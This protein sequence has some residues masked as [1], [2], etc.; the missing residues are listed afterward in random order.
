MSIFRR[1]S[2]IRQDERAEE[3]TLT[4]G[5]LEAETVPAEARLPRGPPDEPGKPEAVNLERED[6]VTTAA[7]RRD[8]F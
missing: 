5:I 7:R 8:S 1:K 2:R 6:P 4:E 3:K